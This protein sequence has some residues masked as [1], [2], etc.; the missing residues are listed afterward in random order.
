L[1]HLLLFF[2]SILSLSQS[3][4]LIRWAEAPP[5]IIGFWRLLGAFFLFLTIH[6]VLQKKDQKKFW[7]STQRHS[8]N[9]ALITGVFFFLHLWTYAFAAQHTRIANTMVLFALNP[10]STAAGSFF[11]LRDKFERQHAM[12]FV[13]AFVGIYWLVAENL[14]WEQDLSG[15]I[16]ALASGALYSAYVLTGKKARIEMENSQLNLVVAGITCLSFLVV[17]V[18]AKEEF[19]NY[20]TKTWIAIAC[21]ILL[22]SF[23]GHWIFTYLLKHMN[24]NFMS[25]GKLAEPALAAV[26]AYFVFNEELSSN[27]IIAFVFALAAIFVLIF[28]RKKRTP[29]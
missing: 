28:G 29:A 27:T 20:P 5:L 17:S 22:P 2:L 25:S 4:N 8:L 3:P 18:L 15:K 24:I 9:W 12:A 21:L 16:A 13:L 26:T 7:Q 6:A 14:I 11:L 23:L 1:G 19:Y 10:I